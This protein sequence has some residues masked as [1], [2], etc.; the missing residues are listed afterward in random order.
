MPAPNYATLYDIETQM[1]GATV[2]AIEFFLAAASIDIQVS[3][4]Q[5][6][7]TA[8]TPRVEVEFSHGAAMLQRTAMGQAMPKQV[9]NAF[10]GSFAVRVYTSRAIPTDNA[11]LHG[12]IRGICRYVLSAGAKGYNQTILPYLQILEML[13]TGASPQI[14]DEKEQDIT[15]LNYHVWFAIRNEAWPQEGP[16]GSAW[17]SA[18]SSAFG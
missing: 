13:P 14:Y 6:S 11:D 8:Q 10:E 12:T 4:S 18:F 7:D 9:P 3:R 17:S 15:E 5:E 2:S 16:G 1:E